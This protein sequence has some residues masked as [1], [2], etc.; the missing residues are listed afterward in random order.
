MDT[1]V[2]TLSREYPTITFVAGDVPHWSPRTRQITYTA[3]N[4]RTALWAILHE[5]SHALLDHQS[6]TSDFNLLGK[7]LAAWE[8]ARILAEKYGLAIDEGHIQ[9]CLDSYRDWVYARSMCPTCGSQGIQHSKALYGCLNC[10]CTW[11]V[12]H[13]R[14]CRPYRLKNTQKHK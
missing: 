14:F 2:N 5:L 3:D 8:H 9:D 12:T 7:E 11:N 4:T 6:Y 1:F 10:E 13:A